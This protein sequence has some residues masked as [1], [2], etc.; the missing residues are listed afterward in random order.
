[1][2]IALVHEHLAQDGGAEKVLQAFQAVFPEAPTYT[3]LYDKDHANPVFRN[4]VIRTSFLQ[5]MPFGLRRYQWYLPWMPTAIERFDL[6]E[7]DVVL[8]SSSAFAKGVITRPD[9]I[10]ICYCHSPTRYLW[11]DTHSYVQEMHYSKLVKKVVPFVLSYIRLW[12]RLAANRVDQFIANSRAVQQRIKKYYQRDSSIIYPPV[13]LDHFK[14]SSEIGSYYLIGGRLVAYKRFDLAIA[15]FNQ[16]GLPLKVFGSGPEEKV[17]RK[18]A[19]GNIEFLGRV[20]DE[21]RAEL[22][23]HAKAF[24]NPQEEDFGITVIE[25]MASGRPVIAYAKGGALET[26][27]EGKT[28]FFFSDQN[29]AALADTVLRCKLET[30]DPAVI[31][32]RAEEYSLEKF[33][34]RIK[35]YIEEQYQNQ[36]RDLTSN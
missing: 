6:S 23:R 32:A 15:A 21:Q 19:K 18:M 1:M 4:K 26:V 10:H 33:T 8:S 7:F 29:W 3:L 28:G 14:P 36:Q 12:D 2:K 13:D 5:R 22:Y 11:N 27:V 16:L 25:A 9:A 20:S 17:L 35:S 31:R 24:I 34:Q 30:L